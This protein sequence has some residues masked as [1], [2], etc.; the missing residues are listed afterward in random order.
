MPVLPNTSA[1]ALMPA[2]DKAS[3]DRYGNGTMAS[4]T[5]SY[6]IT[7]ELGSGTADLVLAQHIDLER[8]VALKIIRQEFRSPRTPSAC[9]KLRPKSWLKLEAREYYP[10]L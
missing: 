3:A 10:D 8:A 9:C 2:A 6:F 5:S 4:S 7:G 1:T